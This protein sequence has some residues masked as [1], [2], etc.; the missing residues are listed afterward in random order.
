MI[1]NKISNQIY[2]SYYMRK[3]KKC[4]ADLRFHPK[5]ST[6]AYSKISIGNRVFINSRAYFSAPNGNIVIGD[7]VLIGADVFLAAG[8]HS[9]DKV[10]L[11]INDQGYEG[12]EEN[13]ILEND[14]WIASRTI[15]LGNVT[16]H[17]GT[18]VGAGSMVLHD[19][20]PYCLCV[21]NPKCQAI[22]YRYS[23]DELMQHLLI[24]GKTEE[25][26]KSIL[27]LRKNMT[28]RMNKG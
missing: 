26:A 19:L 14:V 10:G 16:I 17:E 9:Y 23:D 8:H 18:I 13:I 2:D 15:V 21:G 1:I 12:T 27:C 7:D 11:T 22:K 6:F 24:K 25:E 5:N 28:E 4:G 3:F 20:P